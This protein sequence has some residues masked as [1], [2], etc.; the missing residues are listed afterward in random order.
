MPRLD[1]RAFVASAAVLS[2]I[3]L[4]VTGFGS[5]LS[6][7][8]PVTPSYHAWMTIH[9][10]LGIVFA[11]SAVWHVVL[12]RRALLRHLRGSRPRIREVSR[13]AVLAI[14]LVAVVLFAAVAHVY[15]L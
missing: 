13:E 5:H 6:Q 15:A 1:S 4:P 12:N 8:Y 9:W 11:V 14:A 7:A 2:G 10:S 3:G